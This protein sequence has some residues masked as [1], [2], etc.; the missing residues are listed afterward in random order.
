MVCRSADLRGHFKPRFH[1]HLNG[2]SFASRRLVLF[3]GGRLT[4]L[5][6]QSLAA[7]VAFGYTSVAQEISSLRSASAQ[8]HPQAIGK[9]ITAGCLLSYSK[10]L[11]GWYGQ[12]NLSETMDESRTS[13]N[14]WLPEIELNPGQ[15]P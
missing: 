5:P 1:Y 7:Q 11:G 13:S 14:A 3:G 2:Q 8:S 12:Q 6:S 4:E 9:K 15:R 10:S